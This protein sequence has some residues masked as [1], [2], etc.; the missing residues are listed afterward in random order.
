MRNTKFL[1]MLALLAIS[2]GV[3]GQGMPL[4][5]P[6]D[7]EVD[8]SFTAPYGLQRYPTIDEAIN[9]IP[10]DATHPGVLPGGTVF[11]HPGWYDT[12]SVEV[13]D[14]ALGHI[15]HGITIMGVGDDPWGPYNPAGMV[16]VRG[17][18]L[19]TFLHIRTDDVTVRGLWIENYTEQAIMVDNAFG[20]HLESLCIKSCN[21]GVRTAVATNMSMARVKIAGTWQSPGA[22]GMGVDLGD[23]TIGFEMN[24]VVDFPDVTPLPHNCMIM[25]GKVGVNVG[26]NVAVGASFTD[27][28]I[29]NCAEVGMLFLGGCAQSDLFVLDCYVHDCPT[30]ILIDPCPTATHFVAEVFGC[31]VEN[32]AD[33]G[34]FANNLLANSSYV[35]VNC[36]NLLTNGLAIENVGPIP[37]DA[38]YNYYNPFYVGDGAN[39][40]VGLVDYAPWGL[41]MNPCESHNFSSCVSDV[42]VDD[43]WAPLDTNDVVY[44]GHR[45]YYISTDA[46]ATIESALCKIVDEPNCPDPTI[47][48]AD[49]VY[50]PDPCIDPCDPCDPYDPC[51]CCGAVCSNC[52]LNIHDPEH[53]NLTLVSHNGPA[54]TQIFVEG[55]GICWSADGGTFEGFSVLNDPLDPCTM[56]LFTIGKVCDT[57]CDDVNELLITGNEFSMDTQAWAHA[58]GVGTCPCPCTEQ[59]ESCSGCCDGCETG[60]VIEGV[61]V[62]NNVFSNMHIDPYRNEIC[63]EPPCEPP[64]PCLDPCD[65]LDWSLCAVKLCGDG[66]TTDIA[67]IGNVIFD[68]ASSTFNAAGI[69]VAAGVDQCSEGDCT[70]AIEIHDNDISDIVGLN[71]SIGLWIR[72]CA[73]NVI[74]LGNEIFG[75]GDAIVVECGAK[76]IYIRGDNLHDNERAVVFELAPAA[77]EPDPCCCMSDE[78]L[79]NANVI[80]NNGEGVVNLIELDCC[81]LDGILNYWGNADGPSGDGPG[82]GDSVLGNV[83]YTPWLTAALNMLGGNPIADLNGD[84]VVDLF[85]LAI[86]AAHFGETAP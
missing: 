71:R 18:Y 4:L 57:V 20:T 35:R 84:G 33:W 85:D 60:C 63:C 54:V 27:A 40:I 30:G 8:D 76:D 80:Q 81:P 26:D 3:F 24:S 66:T 10:G 65:C 46:A 1:C 77:C 11:V 39:G 79:L 56:G 6:A 86:L 49:G 43:D 69:C 73:A 37:L 21:T 17:T 9:G 13:Y 52:S 5:G 2:T 31:T 74:N 15:L 82:S 51:G 38:R 42:Q 29:K 23:G 36:N 12:E 72:S 55:C 16:I 14:N 22:V 75:V 50:N 32:C 68:I 19:G 25:D 53:T 44:V 64:Y 59:S 61:D 47:S 34:V 28:E 62:L 78:V 7:V 58:Y 48:V 41:V 67:V 83:A 45:M 70:N